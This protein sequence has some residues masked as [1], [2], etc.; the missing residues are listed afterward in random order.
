MSEFQEIKNYLDISWDDPDTDMRVAGIIKR[1]KAILRDKTGQTDFENDEA[2]KQL[3]FDCCRYINVGLLDEF[4]R[5]YKSEILFF[6]HS[7]RM[8]AGEDGTA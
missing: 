8:G 5:N 7:N 6:A 4:Y 2:A 3:L 1:A